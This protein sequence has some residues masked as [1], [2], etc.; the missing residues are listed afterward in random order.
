LIRYAIGFAIYPGGFGTVDELF[1]LLTLV[2]TG[3]L[4]Q[5]PIVLVGPRYWQGLYQW[6]EEQLITNAYIGERDLTYLELVE[7]DEAATAILLES[8]RREFP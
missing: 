2:Q 8:Y 3:K 4:P 5:R 6:M 7:D 1:E